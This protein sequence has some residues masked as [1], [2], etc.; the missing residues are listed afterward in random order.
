MRLQLW[1]KLGPEFSTQ[2]NPDPVNKTDLESLEVRHN[3]AKSRFEVDLGG[4]PAV[5]D[6][7]RMDDRVS[8]HHTAV[9]HQHRRKGIAAKLVATAL[10]WAREEGLKVRPQCWYVAEFIEKNPEYGDLVD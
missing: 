9:P 2:L 5:A 7:A 10:E 4:Q 3:E 6:Y 8:F 1:F